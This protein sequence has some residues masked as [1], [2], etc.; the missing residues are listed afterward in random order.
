LEKKG[1][2]YLYKVKGI[3]K[4]SGKKSGHAHPFNLN[5]KECP[6]FL[7][8][9]FICRQFRAEKGEKQVQIYVQ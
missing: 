2:F 1:L 7:L 8:A 3:F 9:L 6:N 4:A 5:E